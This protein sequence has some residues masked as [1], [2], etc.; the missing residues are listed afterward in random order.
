ML[1]L[2]LTASLMV[3][4]LILMSP[5][6]QPPPTSR[7]HMPLYKLEQGFLD[8]L[9]WHY[10]AQSADAVCRCFLLSKLKINFIEG[11]ILIGSTFPGSV[12]I[13]IAYGYF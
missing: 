13:N 2:R 4:L 11:D 10:F 5:E 9:Q 3:T 1:E 12:Q 6:E 7:V 8:F